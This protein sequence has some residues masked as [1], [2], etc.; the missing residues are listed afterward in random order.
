MYIWE[1]RRFMYCLPSTRESTRD[2]NS[3]GTSACF[4]LSL[5]NIKLRV[6]QNKVNIVFWTSWTAP[7]HISLVLLSHYHPNHNYNH[8]HH[9]YYHHNHNRHHHHHHHHNHCDHQLLRSQTCLLRLVKVK[10]SKKMSCNFH[11]MVSQGITSLEL[12]TPHR[13]IKNS[14]TALLTSIYSCVLHGIFPQIS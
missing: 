1:K 7:A 3:E 2:C 5:S 8:Y 10:I 12:S 9:Y 6:K 4:H 11:R 14:T 13:P